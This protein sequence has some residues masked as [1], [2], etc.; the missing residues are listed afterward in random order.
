MI[1]RH[2]LDLRGLGCFDLADFVRGSFALVKSFKLVSN[3]SKLPGE[4]VIW[5]SFIRIISQSSATRDCFIYPVPYYY[6]TQIALSL[7]VIR[8]YSNLLG[9]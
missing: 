3:K 1:V 7:L 9:T 4:T 6:I 5:C 8:V 2:G